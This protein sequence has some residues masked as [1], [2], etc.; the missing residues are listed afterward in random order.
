MD[1]VAILEGK[2]ASHLHPFDR[3]EVQLALP[4]LLQPAPNQRLCLSQYLNQS[5]SL[6]STLPPHR[7]RNRSLDPIPKPYS[8]SSTKPL[9]WPLPGKPKSHPPGKHSGG[10]PGCR[11][12]HCLVGRNSKDYGKHLS[13][14][15]KASNSGRIAGA[16]IGT[17]AGIALFVGLIFSI[18]WAIRRRKGR[19]K[20]MQVEDGM[21]LNPQVAKGVV[22]NMS[23]PTLPRKEGLKSGVQVRARTERISRIFRSEAAGAVIHRP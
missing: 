2:E 13:T 20:P 21:E 17:V 6:G 8:G 16:V 15:D 18:L 3:Q 4:A 7:N 10:K 9:L 11:K 12:G 22:F 23:Q 1:Q 19:S 14:I 5:P